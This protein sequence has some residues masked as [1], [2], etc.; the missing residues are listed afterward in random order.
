MYPTSVYVQYMGLLLFSFLSCNNVL[1]Q[2]LRVLTNDLP[3]IEIYGGVDEI[4]IY[5]TS[6]QV[7]L[8][9]RI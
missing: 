8:A 5:I 9:H 3:Y 4:T 7:A 1:Y 2:Y 6:G